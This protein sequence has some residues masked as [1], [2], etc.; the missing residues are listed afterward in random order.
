MYNGYANQDAF[1]EALKAAQ[2]AY[3]EA[4][5]L[6]LVENP[7]GYVHE[8]CDHANDICAALGADHYSPYNH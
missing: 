1:H 5:A 2:P 8:L 4:R 3:L 7:R 6:R